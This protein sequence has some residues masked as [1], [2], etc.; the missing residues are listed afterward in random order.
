VDWVESA[1]FDR[2]LVNTV[3]STYP[4]HEREM[5]LAHFRGLLGLWAHDQHVAA[6]A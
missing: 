6:P 4:E 1:D 3:M 5:F 2:L